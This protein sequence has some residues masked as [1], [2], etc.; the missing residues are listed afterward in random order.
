MKFF[1]NKIATI[2][3]KLTL[4]IFSST[5]K[6]HKFKVAQ[7]SISYNSSTTASVS[8]PYFLLRLIFCICCNYLSYYCFLSFGYSLAFPKSEQIRVNIIIEYVNLNIRTYSLLLELQTL[9]VRKS[10]CHFIVILCHLIYSLL[11]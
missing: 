7:K 8:S 4:T 1:S 9:E 2:L 5:T 10:F 3:K 6:L 11:S